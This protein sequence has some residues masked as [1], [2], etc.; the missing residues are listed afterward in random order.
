M[1]R[2]DVR[3]LHAQN[4]EDLDKKQNE[5]LRSYALARMQHRTGKL[6]NV[7]SLSAL[8]HDI[9]RVMAIKSSKVLGK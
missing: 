6:R 4:M 8:R 1:K 5:L 2:N 9:A 3:A 7:K